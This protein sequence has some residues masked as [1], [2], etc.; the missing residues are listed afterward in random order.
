MK[1]EFKT[2]NSSFIWIFM[3][4]AELDQPVWLAV[5]LL[6]VWKSRDLKT[7]QFIAGM[8]NRDGHRP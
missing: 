3:R 1:D 6:I 2:R 5:R 8:K 7:R 4:I